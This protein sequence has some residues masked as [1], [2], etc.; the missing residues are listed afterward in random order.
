MQL[1]SK[2]ALG[3][4]ASA[5]H[6]TPAKIII[7]DNYFG[8]SAKHGFARVIAGKFAWWRMECL[9]SSQSPITALSGKLELPAEIRGASLN[10]IARCL[11]LRLS[12]MGA[13]ATPSTTK[14]FD[15][16]IKCFGSSANRLEFALSF[17]PWFGRRS[18]ILD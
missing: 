3:R 4:R 17:G 10:S 8:R 11:G 13:H 14:T 6:P 16:R 15:S 9:H 1:A 18:R 12:I 7:A 2:V 5:Q